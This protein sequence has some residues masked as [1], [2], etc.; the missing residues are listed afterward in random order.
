MSNLTERFLNYV[1]IDTQSNPNSQTS[2]SSSNQKDLCLLLSRELKEM[3]I[4][5]TYS[6]QGYVYAFIPSNVDEAIVSIGFCAHVDTSP[7]SLGRNV[8]P[9]V[10]YNYDG[11]KIKLSD[12]WSM[13]PEEFPVLERVKGQDI[14]V[15]DGNTLLGA[16]DKAGIAEIMEYL[17]YIVNHPNFKHGDVYVCFTPDEEIGRGTDNI[18]LK[19]FKPDFA[20][21]LDGSEVGGIEY[22]TFNA[23]SAKVKISGKGIHPGSA[24]GKM[25]NASLVGLEFHSLL[26]VNLNPAFTDGYDGFNHLTNIVGEVESSELSYIIRNHDKALF[27]R[28]KDD[29]VDAQK[30]INK[31]YGYE[32]VSVEITDQYYNMAEKLKN[33]FEII[34]LAREACKNLNIDTYTLPVRGGTDGSRLTFMGILTPNLGTGGY[35]FHGR[36]EFA[37]I[38][39]MN[40]AVKL[41]LEITSLSLSF[42]S[43][44]LR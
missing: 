4:S 42:V 30:Y 26:P 28:Q 21:T 34:E 15:T 2:P 37:S 31:K 22:E 12:K 27:Q 39:Q 3:G 33:H 13:S 11:K 40:Q 14:I 18:D 44:L 36:Y 20:Y 29:F 38:T 1:K 9:R 32:A 19:L 43:S 10:I 7:D 24:K 5:T 16:D 6:E 25:V 35:N 23:A 8:K 17:D 41:L